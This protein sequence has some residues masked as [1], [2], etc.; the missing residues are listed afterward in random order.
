MRWPAP[1]RRPLKQ[2]LR[3]PRPRKEKR[4]NIAENSYDGPGAS[5]LKI[6]KVGAEYHATSLAHPGKIWK[7]ADEQ[8][9]IKAHLTEMHALT[10]K[11]QLHTIRMKPKFET[12]EEAK[13]A[14]GGARVPEKV[15]QE[16]AAVKGS[17]R[18]SPIHPVKGKGNS[19][20]G[21]ETP[22]PPAR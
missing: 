18:Q 1:K 3:R 20:T 12:D 22:L 2:N 15:A 9:A 21:S 5:S 6:K 17:A 13:K 14:A 19:A 8:G 4:M 7:G 16:R 10:G 11:R